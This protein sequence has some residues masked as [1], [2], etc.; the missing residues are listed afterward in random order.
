MPAVHCNICLSHIP[1]EAG[2]K[3]EVVIFPCGHG[4]CTR[5]TETLF[6]ETRPRCP[7]CRTIL[8]H[9]E[10]HPF[11]LELVDSATVYT[12]AVID[13]VNQMNADTPLISVKK[14]NQ[15][16]LK[17]V[18]DGVSPGDRM[19]ADLLKAIE[20]FQT[21]IVPLFT[22]TDEQKQ[23]VET[24]KKDMHKNRREVDQLNAKLK[25]AENLQAEV[26]K[27][28]SSLKESERNM[29]E[30][31]R[32]AEVA[33]ENLDKSNE[34]LSKWQKRA[35][36][37]EEE[38]KRMR[39]TLYRQNNDA[40]QT[41]RQNKKL[42]EKVASLTEKLMLTE[43]EPVSDSMLGYDGDFSGN[44]VSR[45]ISKTP[46]SKRSPRQ[47]TYY[48]ENADVDVDLDYEPMPGANFISDWQLRDSNAAVL[49]KRRIAGPLPP[50]TAALQLDAKGRPLKPI[51]IG[52]KTTI[53][54][55]R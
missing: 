10:G 34:A 26:K 42:S 3:P 33:K 18:K 43:R 47:T 12:E 30:A 49:K 55:G 11:Y 9:R 31:I 24:L 39:D 27:F 1:V 46:S 22:R 21:R 35:A 20:D 44:E 2:S 14:A 53:R 7:H 23:E 37:L 38:N 28:Q 6:R 19:A 17:V 36:D 48:D 16:L 8:H 4:Y 13:G 5:C 25:K 50:P 29:E 52:P 51:Q 45:T 54:L 41:K 32:L 15:K 40:K